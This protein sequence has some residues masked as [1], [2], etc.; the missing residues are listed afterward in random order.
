MDISERIR[1]KRKENG[2]TQAQL[3]EKLYITQ[4][5]VCDWENGR[6][7]PDYANIDRIAEALHTTS[8]YIRWG[9]APWVQKY[10]I[11]DPDHME[12]KIRTF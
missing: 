11:F 4:Q 6:K 3:A 7:Q 2:L 1:Q 8:A 5:A 10:E 12:E 9:N